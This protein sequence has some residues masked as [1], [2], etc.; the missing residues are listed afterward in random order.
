M[1]HYVNKTTVQCQQQEPEQNAGT[2]KLP[3]LNQQLLLT[4]STHELDFL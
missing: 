3:E 2:R 4:S 1:Q